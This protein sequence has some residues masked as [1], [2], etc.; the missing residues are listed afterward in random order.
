MIAK[1]KKLREKGTR[2]DA[3]YFDALVRA[4]GRRAPGS[5]EGVVFHLGARPPRLGE[6]EVVIVLL[7]GDEAMALRRHTGQAGGRRRWME[8]L[9]LRLGQVEEIVEEVTRRFA[10]LERSAAEELTDAERRVLAKGGLGRAKAPRRNPVQEAAEIYARMLRE[11]LD[12]AETA[13]HLGIDPSRVRQRLTETPPTLF[14]VKV[15][16][17]WRLPKFQFT[18]TGLVPGIDAVIARLPRDVHPVAVERWLMSPHPDLEAERGALSPL[19]WLK[20]GR[21]VSVVA[22]LASSL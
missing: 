4:L 14:G 12:V 17:E 22:D 21:P 9:R 19:D 6:D 2:L 7:K 3:E 15:G 20:T 5:G 18:R 1:A 8:E 13:A 16:F 10:H 11:G